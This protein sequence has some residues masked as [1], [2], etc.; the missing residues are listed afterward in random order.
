MAIISIFDERLPPSLEWGDLPEQIQECLT[1]LV[2]ARNENGD[3]D[4]LRQRID[5]AIVA[6]LVPFSDANG[7]EKLNMLAGVKLAVDD[8]EEPEDDGA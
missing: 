8:D 1:G 3:N 6:M 7:S 2:E 5:V 4:E